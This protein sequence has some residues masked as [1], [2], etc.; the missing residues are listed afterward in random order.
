MVAPCRRRAFTVAVRP[1]WAA[2]PSRNNRN[3]RNNV[4]HHLNQTFLH[5]EL[6]STRKETLDQR[7]DVASV[8]IYA[9]IATTSIAVAPV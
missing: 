7:S 9:Q 2:P 5:R 6:S 3:G 4:V 1:F 8:R